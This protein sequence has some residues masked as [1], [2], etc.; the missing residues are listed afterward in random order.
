MQ[1]DFAHMI[2]PEMFEE[3]VL[4]SIKE[5]CQY[6][7]YS[8]YHLD[9]KGQIAH[10]DLLLSIKELN[11]IQWS[12]P[13]IPLDPP[14]DSPKWYPYFERIQKAGKLLYIWAKPENVERLIS[15]LSPRGLLIGTSCE[16]EDEVKE[17]LHKVKKWSRRRTERTFF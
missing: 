16:S 14:H 9:G 10:L 11:G 3:F 4:P 12:V 2:S 8:I 17:L 5:Q 15:D 1:C 13:V 6:L 7:D